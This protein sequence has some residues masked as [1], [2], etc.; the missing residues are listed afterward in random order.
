MAGTLGI[1]VLALVLLLRE[2][3]RP[4]LVAMLTVTLLAGSGILSASEAFSGFS[5]N[6]VLT[7]ISV[8]ILAEGLSRSGVSEMA[9]RFILRIGGRKQGVLVGLFMAAGASLSLFLNNIAAAAVL[10]PSAGRASEKAGFSVSGLLMPLVYATIMGGMATLL[11]SMNIVVG[12]VFEDSGLAGFGLLDFLPIGIPVVVAGIVYMIFWG[13]FRLPGTEETADPCGRGRLMG[14]YRMNELFFKARIPK[15]SYLSGRQLSESTLREDFRLSLAAVSRGG[16]MLLSLG[17]DTVLQAGDVLTL[18]GRASEFVQ[19]DREPRLE[20]LQDQCISPADV[21]TTEG[22]LAEV[23]LSPRSSL[24]GSTLRDVKFLQKYGMNVIAIWRENQPIRRDVR[25]ETLEYGDAL[26]GIIPEE[27]LEL[28]QGNPDLIPITIPTG[29]HFAAKKA[30]LA[31]TITAASLLVILLTGLPMS[32]VLF[33]G[34][35][36]MLVCGVIKMEQAYRSIDWKAVF[37]VAG[38]LPLATAMHHTGLAERA[39]G[40]LLAFAAGVS[41]MVVTAILFLGTA[42]LVQAVSGVAVAALMAP[43]AVAAAKADY[44]PAAALAMA[45]ALGSSMAFLTP[46][47]HPVNTLVMGA[48]GYRFRDY[49]RVGGPLFMILTLVILAGMAIRWNLLQF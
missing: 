20:I 14:V 12:S 40:T 33:S 1:L 17:P 21:E 45:V 43:V 29:T 13:R 10:I 5:S 19:M 22:I 35:V 36:L 26:L 47:G 7:I 30:P 2:V 37:L 25:K 48:G 11:T 39:T 6:A 38:M 46:L 9:A 8:F 18:K 32:Q 34:A 23:M 4:D 24:I 41:P 3:L 31:I 42:F 49:R 27:R 44:A 28:L 15:G 16:E